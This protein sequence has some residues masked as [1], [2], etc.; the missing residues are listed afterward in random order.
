VA[1]AWSE[2]HSRSYGLSEGQATASEKP[3]D[4]E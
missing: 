3:Q 2:S 4:S 1:L